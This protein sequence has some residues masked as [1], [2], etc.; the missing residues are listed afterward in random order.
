MLRALGRVALIVLVIQV[1]F[2]MMLRSGWL[3]ANPEL[4]TGLLA[5]A[6]VF[7]PAGVWAAVDGY[8]WPPTRQVVILWAVVAAA[9]AVVNHVYGS[10]MG[11][12]GYMRGLPLDVW[13]QVLTPLL[14]L[15]VMHAAPAALLVL[16]GSGLR[17]Y[18]GSH[19]AS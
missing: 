10:M 7:L 2:E 14:P 17:R 9:V 16:L 5:T 19:T 11:L 8:R 18:R 15:A 13:A 6:L 1:S 4:A 3:S 12:W